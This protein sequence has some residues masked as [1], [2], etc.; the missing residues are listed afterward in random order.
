ML[1][2]KMDFGLKA[3]SITLLIISCP[4]IACADDDKRLISVTSQGKVNVIANMAKVSLAI[5]QTGTTANT[6]RKKIADITNAVLDEIKDEK[7]IKYQTSQLNIWP[8]YDPKKRTE[9]IS[10]TGNQQV[11][12]TAVVDK[13][14]KLIDKALDKGANKVNGYNLIPSDEALA[15]AKVKALKLAS[16]N[17]KSEIKTVLESFNLD[18]KGI[19]TIDIVN[20]ELPRPYFNRMALNSNAMALKAA[21]ETTITEGENEVKA[22]VRITVKFEED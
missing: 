11:T 18:N 14:G 12:F 22:S 2:N 13:A 16:Q 21:H 3:L 7:P 20:L 5:E 6:V 17:A 4:Q 9:I 19:Q 8:K 1:N 15:E 10:Y